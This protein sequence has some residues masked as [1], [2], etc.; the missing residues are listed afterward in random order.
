MVFTLRVEVAKTKQQLISLGTK[1]E[2]TRTL[3]EQ[4]VT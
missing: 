3:S 4:F 2:K 1:I